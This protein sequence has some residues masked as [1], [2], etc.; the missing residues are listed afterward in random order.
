L[1]TPENQLT[2]EENTAYSMFAFFMVS[3]IKKR[4]Y[5]LYIPISKVDENIERGHKRD[6]ILKEKFWFRKDIQKESP[7][8]WVELTLGEILHGKVNI[9][10]FLLFKSIG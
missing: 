9:R 3:M 10:E 1:R 8:E 2:S 6:A 7:D 5:N 4:E